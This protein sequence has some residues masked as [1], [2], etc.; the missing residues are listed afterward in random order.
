MA[1]LDEQ[2]IQDIRSKADLVEVISHYI[3]VQKKGKGYAAVC[4][5]HDDHDPS[6]SI[7]VDKQIY[8]CFVCGAGG[9]VFTFVKNFEHISFVEAV[10]SVASFTG[11][12][13]E[14]TNLPQQKPLDEATS[15][16]LKAY[17]LANEYLSYQLH[18]ASDVVT[19]LQQRGISKALQETFAMGYNPGGDVL[20]TFLRAKKT[21]DQTLLDANLSLQ[22]SSGLH[23]VFKHRITIPIHDRFGKIIGYTA[24]IV[25][26]HEGAKYINTASTKLYVKSDIIFNFHRVKAQ[27]HQLKQ[28]FVVEGAMDVIGMAKGGIAH[29]VAT[30]GTSVTRKQIQQLKLLHTDIVLFYDGDKAGKAATYRFGA[31]AQAEGLSFTIVQNPT[32]LDPDEYG[33]QFGAQGLQD[34]CAKTISWMDFL[35]EYL[36]TKYNL[37]NYADLKKYA[38]ELYENIERLSEPFEQQRYLQKLNQQTGFDFKHV[39]TQAQVQ[40]TPF[41]SQKQS[42]SLDGVEIAQY[43]LLSQML[44]SNQACAQF[45]EQ[46]GFL[47]GDTYNQLAM[48]IV[49]YYRYNAILHVADFANFVEQ[50]QVLTLLTNI[51]T[52]ELAPKEYSSTLVADCIL[53]LKHILLTRRIN[54]L[55]QH[56]LTTLEQYEELVALQ[57]ERAELLH[58]KN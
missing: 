17:E 54:Q 1:K 48:Y 12:T 10:A 21:D 28:V 16:M 36:K 44:L 22:G 6:L 58:G 13:V 27:Q 7:S 33:T 15:N 56:T 26:G 29:A 43:T 4:P 52:W 14:L 8:K 40:P 37:Q 31:I 3:P 5:F 38:K 32:E 9:N 57:K 35:F 24:R 51:E 11:H 45:S 49:E 20:T 41:I 18:Q 39:E 34:L 46:L 53:K 42:V 30:L 19:Y 2:L 50:E 55:K 25:E 23:D 47:L